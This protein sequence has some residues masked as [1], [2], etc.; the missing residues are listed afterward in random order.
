MSNSKPDY[1]FDGNPAALVI[2]LCA[3][4][5]VDLLLFLSS[6][7]LIRIAAY[8]VF[9]FGL[10]F[11][12][13][14]AWH[15]SYVRFGKLRHRD[16][17][18]SL[19]D[20]KGNE[21]VLDVGTGRGLLLIGA[22]KRAGKT[23]GVDIWRKQDMANNAPEGALHNSE[24]EGVRDKIEIRNEDIRK[25]SFPS[26]SFDVVLSNL[27][28]HNIKGKEGRDQA[29][30]EIARVLKPGGTA[31]ISDGGFTKAYRDV[32]R[33]EGMEAKI[34]KARFPHRSLWLHA[35]VAKKKE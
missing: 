7:L 5:I 16:A 26:G 27:C 21:T 1:G 22:A 29:C 15:F 25:T 33:N 6:S 35:V 3:V 34:V 14:T 8:I 10:G 13:V 17:L 30:R 28:L 20:W 18:L 4:A 23:V 12:V 11:L 19:V 9:A 24:L 2:S 32:F 31:V